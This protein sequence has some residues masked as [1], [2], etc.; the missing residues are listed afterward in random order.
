MLLIPSLIF[1]ALS[2]SFALIIE[3][4]ILTNVL[5]SQDFFVLL[6]AATVEELSKYIFLKQYAKQYTSIIP[7]SIGQAFIL[8]TSFGLGFAVVE[9]SL[10]SY[11]LQIATIPFWAIFGSASLHIIT[12]IIFAVFLFSFYQKRSTDLTAIALAIFLHILYNTLVF[13][14]LFGFVCCK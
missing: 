11:K 2:A 10:M 4:L 12:G 14:S 7:S 8:G 1:G 3:I 9:L 5:S 13:V 6:G